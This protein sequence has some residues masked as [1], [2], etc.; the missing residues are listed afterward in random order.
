MRERI[1]N[2]A[3]TTGEK[4][5]Q[6]GERAKQAL[7]ETVG[8]RTRRVRKLGRSAVKNTVRVTREKAG[9]ANDRAKQAFEVTSDRAKQT[10]ELGRDA[11]QSYFEE[12]K[13]RK[14]E[15]KTD[16]E[17]Q[18][19]NRD[20]DDLRTDVVETLGEEPGLFRK[21]Y[22]WKAERIEKKITKAEG[23][24]NE[25][26]LRERILKYR[27]NRTDV[28]IARLKGKLKNSSGSWLAK[29][30]DRQRRQKL[31][32]LK[33][34]KRRFAGGLSEHKKKRRGRPEELRKEIDKLIKK[35]VDAQYRKAQRKILKERHD[36][37]ILNPVKRADFLAK[38]TD[39]DKKEIIREAILLVRKKNIKK[40]LLDAY[41]DV[42]ESLATRKIGE[43]YERTI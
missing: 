4:A 15:A 12:R 26:G 35:K 42:D 25:P 38:M 13:I 3:K 8:D 22:K 37:G 28:K 29:H 30:I 41:Y 17:W 2:T 21:R 6:T 40:G 24:V 39:R 10:L 9:Q 16:Y 32:N 5:K 19:R 7:F 34:N 18:R 33:Y 31:D 14:E 20:L 1:K 36:I 23:R 11:V 43:E 27:E